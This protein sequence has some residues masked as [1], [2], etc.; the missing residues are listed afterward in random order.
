MCRL[1]GVSRSGYY[2]WLNGCIGNRERY[3]YELLPV[4]RE[5]HQNSRYLY[6]SPRIHAELLR[7]GYK[8]SRRLVASIMRQFS[9]KSKIRRSYK[10]TT[11]RN[12]KDRFSDNLLKSGFVAETPDEVWVSDITYVRANGKWNY[13]TKIMDL[14]SRKVVGYSFS[15]TLNTSDTVVAA[16]RF[17][18]K[19]SGKAPLIFHS[20]RG[21]QYSSV[22]FRKELERFK[23]LQSMTSDGHCFD[24]AYAESF[25]KTIKTELIQF[26][27]G[28]GWNEIKNAIFEY[29]ECFYNR[30]R[31]HSGI[32]YQTP[33]EVYERFY[34]LNKNIA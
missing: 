7:L 30:K 20:D 3:R 19:H 33:N 1:L 8:C 17:A 21:S 9:I 5:I 28:M 22:E 2:K 29:I 27:K 32:G 16:F 15:T 4:I 18:V 10:R 13:L 34:E 31:L 25:F 6:G 24:N 11:V 23:V 26:V 14:Y 12:N